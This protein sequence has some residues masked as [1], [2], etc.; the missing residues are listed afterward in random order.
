MNLII[1]NNRSKFSTV[2]NAFLDEAKE[3][4]E[5]IYVIFPKKYD[6]EKDY[7][8]YENI[9]F[10]T[11]DIK[12]FVQAGFMAVLNLFH[13]NSLSDYLLART[14]GFNIKFFKKYIRS[15]FSAN[16]LYITSTGLLK[17]PS[18]KIVV[19]STWYDAN[20]IAAAKAAKKFPNI[21]AASYA[22]SY[23]V[24]FR[25]NAFTAVVCDRFK[26]K[27]L[28]EI[29]FISKNVMDEYIARNRDILSHIDKY[30][31]VHFGSKKKMEGMSLCSQDGVFRIVTCSGITP[32][33]RLDVLARA[34]EQYKGSTYIEWTILGDGPDCEK[35]KSI[36]GKSIKNNVHVLFKGSLPNDEV[37]AYYVNNSV[38][39][40]INVSSSEGLPVSIM[41]AMSYGIPALATDVGGNHEI[42]TNDTGYLIPSKITP[43]TLCMQITQIVENLELCH[44]K[45]KAA[46]DMWNE[47]YRI[48]RNISIVIERL[49]YGK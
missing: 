2:L 43:E 12:Y 32:V 11:P 21:F 47:N 4:F 28:N 24:D 27:Y 41:E 25:K 37:H 13:L 35:L 6:A 34:L 22:H 10:I 44:K 17:N 40:F 19:F 1:Y 14:K 3:S 18:E 33:K 49:K 26:E 9:K 31:T 30:K 42:V 8:K 7:G 46:Y 38:D 23:E 48:D 45:R 36:V 16:I 29:Y 5:N 20:A 39:L 15:L